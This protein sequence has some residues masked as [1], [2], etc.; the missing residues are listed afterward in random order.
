MRL[1]QFTQPDGDPVSVNPAEVASVERTG[2]ANNPRTRITLV[3]GRNHTVTEEY[4]D[5]VAALEG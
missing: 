1:V 5:V 3:N 2:G 4:D